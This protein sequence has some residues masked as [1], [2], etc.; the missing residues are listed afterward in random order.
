[1]LDNLSTGRRENVPRRRGLPRARPAATRAS[2]SSSPTSTSTSST[3]TPRRP[4]CASRSRTRRPTPQ[5]TCSAAWRCSPRAEARRRAHVPLR[6]E[7]RHGLRRAGGLPLR[8][9][10]IRCGP[11]SPYGV[12]KSRVELY[13]EAFR[14]SGDLEPIVLR[15]ANVYGPRQEPKGEAGIVAILAEKLLAGETAAD[16][17]RRRADAR[18]RLRRAT[19]SPRNRAAIERWIAGRL[20]RRHRRRDHASTQ[21]YAHGRRRLGRRSG[22]RG[23]CRRSPPSSARNVPRRQPSSSATSALRPRRRLDEGLALTLPWYRAA[24]TAES[25]ARGARSIRLPG[26]L[27]A[28][29]RSRSLARST[30]QRPWELLGARSTRRSRR[31][32]RP[33]IEIALDPRAHLARRPDRD[34]ARHARSRPAR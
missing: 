15:Y 25:A 22:R 17:R 10:R 30:R 9:G 28:R 4:T 24:R 5:P 1:M 20:Q 23:T 12:A 2:T 11:S 7:R 32:R 18:L 16:L 19:S 26:A 27:V 6:L 31:C 13:L 33:A 21:L 8:R 29:C 14:R 34:R 3:T